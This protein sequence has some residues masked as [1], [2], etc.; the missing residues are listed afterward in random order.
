LEVPEKLTRVKQKLIEP[1]L[2]IADLCRSRGIRLIAILSPSQFALRSDLRSWFFQK[3]KLEGKPLKEENFDLDL[4]SK[5]TGRILSNLGVEF[6][7]LMPS[8][9]DRIEK[10]PKHPYYAPGDTH[11]NERGNIAAAEIAGN[12]L[13]P[14]LCK[15]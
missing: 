4:P 15:P 5:V 13:K 2:E 7:D 11:W 6:I 1:L 14:F 10:D 8:F 12:L 3:R 9:R